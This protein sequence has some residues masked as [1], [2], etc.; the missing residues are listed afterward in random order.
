MTKAN[1]FTGHSLS[2]FLTEDIIF[3]RIVRKRGSFFTVY[4]EC[5]MLC[6]DL[7]R[8][9]FS[10]LFYDLQLLT[11]HFCSRPLLK[12]H[13]LHPCIVVEMN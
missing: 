7:Y 12:Y 13:I 4:P 8:S 9:Y 2:R 10:S 11:V 5:C 6:Y 1:A 3:K